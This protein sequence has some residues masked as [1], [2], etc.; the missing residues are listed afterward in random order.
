V[1]RRPAPI[2]ARLRGF[3]QNLCAGAKEINALS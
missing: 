1:W 2:L 3:G